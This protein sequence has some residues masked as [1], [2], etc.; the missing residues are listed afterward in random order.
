[1]YDS[2][3]ECRQAGWE[4]AINTAVY[5]TNRVPCS[6]WKSKTPNEVFLGSRP[7]L[8]NLCV[9][10]SKGFAHIDRTKRQKLD[11][12]GFYCMF[13]GYSTMT[14]GYRVIDSRTN[15]LVIVRTAV[16]E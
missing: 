15:K 5:I 6:V 3:K 7:N 12:K 8:S 16:F 10:G 1:M 4:E 9:F 2:M 11:D 13:V 14:K